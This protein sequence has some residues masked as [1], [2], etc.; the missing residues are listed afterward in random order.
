[1]PPVERFVPRFAAEPPQEELPYGRWEVRLAE[2]FLK[3]A[4]SLEGDEDLGEPG[5]IVWYPDR[6]WHGHT[7]VPATSRTS[8]GYELFGYVRFLPAPPD[9]EPSEFSAVADVTEETAERH[10]DWQMDLCEEV[11]GGWRGH[12]GSVATMTLVW[13]RP[14]V[15]G[16]RIVTAELADLAVDQCELVQER[17]TLLAPDD[18]RGDLL[19]IKLFDVKGRELARESLYAGDQEEEAEE[20]QEEEA[21]E[22]ELEEE[23]GALG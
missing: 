12:F 5:P 20:E 11:V 6:T 1:M 22:Q 7:Y 9:G 21:Q 14:L 19:E 4:L 18:Y 2:Q 8:T 23:G 13:G 17:F 10:P 15:S 3:A 16:G